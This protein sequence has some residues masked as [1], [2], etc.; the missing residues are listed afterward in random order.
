MKLQRF[1]GKNTKSVLDEIRTILGEEALIVSN[2]KVG[3]KTEIIA[4]GEPKS[5]GFTRPG[6]SHRDSQASPK[7]EE[8]FSSV[9][10]SQKGVN[11][12]NQDPDPWSHI[13]SINDEI[14]SIKSSLNQLPALSPRVSQSVT[15][16]LDQEDQEQMNPK[17]PLQVLKITSQGCHIVWGERKSGKTCIIKELLKRRAANHDETLILRLPHKHSSSDSHL[18]A[19]AAK[20]SVNL[21]LVNRSE[22]IEP[23]INLL[24]DN[25]LIFV[26]ADLSMLASLAAKKEVSW[27]AKSSNYIIDEDEKQTE[28]VSELF[29]KFHA[30]TPT[31]VSSK[32][33]EEIS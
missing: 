32:I 13:K 2:T 1:V 26:E 15:H 20:Y 7:R 10:V 19:I 21:L 8:S 17:D 11:S 23:V 29:Q 5:S 27:L 6:N 14:R 33:I 12:E 18:S 24:E 4:A 25:H 30:E 16:S 9:M 22:S 3:S 28:L 31:T